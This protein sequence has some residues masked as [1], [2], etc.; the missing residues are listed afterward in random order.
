MTCLSCIST[1][2][3][4]NVLVMLSTRASVVIALTYLSWNILVSILGGLIGLLCIQSGSQVAN[5]KLS[6][7]LPYLWG[8]LSVL[9]TIK[10]QWTNCRLTF[11]IRYHSCGVPIIHVEQKKKHYCLLVLHDMTCS[12]LE[13]Y[14]SLKST[15]SFVSHPVVPNMS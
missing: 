6:W 10:D 9:M 8:L 11:E 2:M 5:A 12:M 1:T 4:A 15:V 7:F 13:L 3:T 14:E